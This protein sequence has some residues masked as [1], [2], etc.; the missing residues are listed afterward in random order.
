MTKPKYSRH[1]IGKYSLWADW[2][3]TGADFEGGLKSTFEKYQ[4]ISVGL[5]IADNES[6]EEVSSLY[7]EIKFD[8]VKY[9]W[10]P[11]AEKI[12]GLT[13]E[14]LADHGISRQNALE[15]IIDFLSEYF[16]Y[17]FISALEETPESKICFGGHNVNFDIMATQQLFNDFGFNIGIHHVLLDTSAAA[18]IAVG[19]SKSNDVFTYFGAEE[20]TTH[21][22]LEDVRQSL[23]V[24]HGIKKLVQASLNG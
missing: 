19:L 3:T 7:V 14:Y 12:H 20:R 11:E 13:E 6:F 1:D 10:T 4:G 21:N 16:G 22:A 24:A 17:G 15:S 2:E 8:S 23:A 9:L 18:F 5:I